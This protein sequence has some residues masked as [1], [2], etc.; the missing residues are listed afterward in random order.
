MGGTDGRTDGREWKRRAGGQQQQPTNKQQQQ[1]AS[2]QPTRRCFREKSLSPGHHRARL[3]LRQRI[4]VIRFN[5]HKRACVRQGKA[6]SGVGGSGSGRQG[7]QAGEAA[8]RHC[9]GDVRLCSWSCTKVRAVEASP[10]PNYKHSP[11]LLQSIRTR[12]GYWRATGQEI[13]I[14]FLNKGF[15]RSRVCARTRTGTHTHRHAVDFA[16]KKKNK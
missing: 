15:G 8:S 12:P 1:Q 3:W 13:R 10:S 6:S 11:T 9:D 4:S 16:G 5:H 7:K 2:P 14:A